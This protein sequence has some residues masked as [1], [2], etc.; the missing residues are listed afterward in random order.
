[1][2]DASSGVVGVIKESFQKHP[3]VGKGKFVRREGEGTEGVITPV[4]PKGLIVDIFV[5]KLKT[6]ISAKVPLEIMVKFSNCIQVF[7]LTWGSNLCRQTKV[8]RL[9]NIDK[10]NYQCGL[11]MDR[12]IIIYPF[13]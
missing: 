2:K 9:T 13:P 4:P 12:A 10:I 6:N 7:E 11:A 8:W 5:L 1:M 3:K